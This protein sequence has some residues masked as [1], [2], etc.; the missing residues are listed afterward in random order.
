[1]TVRIDYALPQMPGFTVH[2]SLR[3]RTLANPSTAPGV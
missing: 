3:A 1:M 2:E